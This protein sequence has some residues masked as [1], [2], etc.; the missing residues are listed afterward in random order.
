MDLR[1]R[2][3]NYFFVLLS[4]GAWGLGRFWS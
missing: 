4:I 3:V 1:D 2:T